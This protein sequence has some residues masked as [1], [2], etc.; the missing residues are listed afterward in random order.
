MNSKGITDLSIKCKATELL[1]ANIGKI[2]C[3]FGIRRVLRYNTKCMIHS[4]KTDNLVLIRDTDKRMKR[5][6]TDKNFFAMFKFNKG[7]CIQNIQRTFK[8][9]ENKSNKNKCKRFEQILHQR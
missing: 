3:N 2:L 6:A 4:E 8:I 7:L 1:K 5:Q 9:Q